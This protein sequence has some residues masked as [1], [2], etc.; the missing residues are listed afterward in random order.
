MSPT[1]WRAALLVALAWALAAPPAGAQDAEPG[2]APEPIAEEPASEEPASEE[3]A[4]EQAAAEAPEAHAA[5]A[6]PAAEAPLF[7]R[8]PPPPLMVVV[9]P[10]RRVP[11]AVVAAARE[12]LVAQV[13][14]MAGGR[15]VHAATAE[16]LLEAIEACEDDACLGAQLAEAGA[17]AGVVLRLRRAR[18]GLNATLELR[19]PVSGAPRLEAVEGALPRD[20]D[21]VPEAL[22]AL[23]AQLE[24]AM[25]SPPPPPATLTVTVNVDGAAV[26]VDGHDLGTSPVAPVDLA[27]GEHEVV[28][29]MPG[30]HAVRRR[31][32]IGA[33]EQAR[34]DVTL[35][36]VGVAP[37]PTGGAIADPDDPWA[38]PRDEGGDLTSEWWFWT[39]V[40]VGAAALIG[41]AI[42]IGVAASGGDQGPAMPEGIPL[43]PI[44]GGM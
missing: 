14:P 35:R 5:P 40:G 32:R 30:Y 43:P 16:A 8:R 7:E 28:V 11:D 4:A 27:E 26:Q 37:E 1:T 33:G 25:P 20:A 42:G 13:T 15:P 18:R 21:E 34:V 22:A 41:G 39:I 36:E 29:R 24:E 19:D 31:T 2:A 9:L 44:T 6:A 12:A 3:P 38:Q 10:A 17:Q 23:S